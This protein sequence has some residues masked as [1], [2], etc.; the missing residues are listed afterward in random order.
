MSACRGSQD[1]DARLLVEILAFGFGDGNPWSFVRARPLERF[2]GVGEPGPIW[3]TA[4][5]PGGGRL[6]CHVASGFL[7]A[8]ARCA[9]T[10]P[11]PVL[12]PSAIRR[13]ASSSL[14][15]SAISQRHVVMPLF[16]TIV[17][18]A[19]ASSRPARK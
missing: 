15:E 12:R 5:R 18:H 17:K 6:E 3:A 7:F 1:I 9:V 16:G 14:I 13:S 4:G 2:C 19:S 8:L 11:I 10:C